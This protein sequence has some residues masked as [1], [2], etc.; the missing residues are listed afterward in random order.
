MQDL[1]SLGDLFKHALC[2]QGCTD[3]KWHQSQRLS[4]EP[5]HED[6]ESETRVSVQHDIDVS[7]RG[8]VL[9]S[10]AAHRSIQTTRL[11]DPDISPVQNILDIDDLDE[12]LL[13]HRE[14]VWESH[15]VCQLPHIYCIARTIG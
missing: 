9:A 7:Q 4:H 12:N 14:K 10:R 1:L 8:K 15:R 3:V 5:H 2:L 11:Q 6:A 13:Q